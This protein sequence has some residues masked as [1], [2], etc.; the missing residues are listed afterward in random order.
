MDLPNALSGL[1]GRVVCWD[2]DRTLGVFRPLGRDRAGPRAP[3]PEVGLRPH[4]REVIEALDEAGAIQVITTASTPDHAERALRRSGVRGRFRRIYTGDDLIPIYGQPTKD[5]ALVANDFGLFGP[6]VGARM[7]VVGDTLTLDLPCNG[8]VFVWERGGANVSARV[9]LW[10]LSTLAAAG[11]GDFLAGYRALNHA[12]G[13]PT[14]LLGGELAAPLHSFILKLWEQSGT[15]VVSL[16]S[17]F[18]PLPLDP[19]P[20]ERGGR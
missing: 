11:G 15:P 13:P 10:I 16:L 12:G 7:I 8:P 4:V 20:A 14:A 18:D 17:E 2:L 5:Y 9:T 6:E 19:L 1:A 3:G